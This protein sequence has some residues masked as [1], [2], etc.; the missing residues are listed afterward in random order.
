MSVKQHTVGV[1]IPTDLLRHLDSEAEQQ[2]TTRAAVM[3]RALV[4]H[5]QFRREP[6]PES[7]PLGTAAV[8]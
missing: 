6:E 4:E 1:A 2:M 3:R 8:A 5:L 7:E